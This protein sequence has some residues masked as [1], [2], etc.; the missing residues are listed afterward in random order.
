MVIPAPR[1]SLVTTLLVLVVFL[2]TFAFLL[3]GIH[4]EKGSDRPSFFIDEAH[5]IGE[6]YFGRLF[7]GLG[8]FSNPLWGTD[9]YARTNPPVPKYV[10]WTGLSLSGQSVT[11]LGLQ[12]EFE[13]SWRR[14]GV[15]RR[16]VPDESLKATRRVS[17]LFGALT[18][19]CLFFAGRRLGGTVAGLVAVVLFLGHPDAAYHGR[20]GLPDSMLWFFVLLALPVS[21]RASAAYRSFLARDPGE[22]GGKGALAF[23]GAAALAPGVVTALAV[24]TKLN[25]ALAG[26]AFAGTMAVTA[27][28]FRFEGPAGGARRWG[29]A[30]AAVLG[31][32]ALSVLLFVAI[33]PSYYRQ[34]FERVRETLRLYADWTVKQQVDPGGGLLGAQ[35]RVAAVGVFTVGSPSSPLAALAGRPGA[36]VTA[37]GFLAGILFLGGNAARLIGKSAGEGETAAAT[38]CAGAL[39]WAALCIGGTTLWLPLAWLRYLLLPYL[40]FCLLAGVGLA[41]GLPRVLR[42]LPALVSRSPEEGVP[43]ARSGRRSRRA[44]GSSLTG[45]GE[46]SRRSGAVAMALLAVCWAVLT[47]TSWVIR[48]ELIPPGSGLAPE[49]AGG[50]SR[51]LPDPSGAA[52]RSAAGAHNAGASLLMAGRIGEAIPWLERA[53]AL[54]AKEDGP[55]LEGKVRASR[56]LMD[57]ARARDGTGSRA[58]TIAAVR[59]HRESVL[60]VRDAMV[61]GDSKIRDEYDAILSRDDRLIAR[62]AALPGG[63]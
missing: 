28:G 22:A 45:E 34:P 44:S 11:D 29:S 60:A 49:P 57:L 43:G 1:R 10:F 17:A 31:T 39:V 58:G 4:V 56:I 53:L 32:A 59:Q 37:L 18:A 23:L 14:P 21:W 25:G 9:F 62:L 33:N 30:A 55:S 3:R 24:G 42:A 51:R 8:D 47:L 15:L 12:E 38:E 7:L 27:W 5:K 26:I 41:A 48:P 36:W 61:S 46:G 63:D 6:A 2:A 40:A 54:T 13:R 35:E 16:S 20:V 52:G 50:E 19:A